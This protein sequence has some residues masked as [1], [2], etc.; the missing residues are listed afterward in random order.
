MALAV[1]SCNVVELNAFGPDDP[2]GAR[3]STILGAYFEAEH[4]L[5]F[6]R[7]L[8]RR[9]AILAVAWG[10]YGAFLRLD[11]ALIGGFLFIAAAAGYAVAL[12]WRTKSRLDHLIERDRI[13]RAAEWAAR[14]GPSIS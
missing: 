7:L 9:L 6:R 4:A 13:S 10:F 1:V 8:C 3:T 14:L 5:A 11:G 12:E 2:D